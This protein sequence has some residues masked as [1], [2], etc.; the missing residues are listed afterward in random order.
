MAR[1]PAQ[2]LDYKLSS[3][4][5]IERMALIEQIRDLLFNHEMD[6]ITEQ[7]RSESQV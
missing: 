3:L 5:F 1:T 4:P 2:I 6:A 7:A